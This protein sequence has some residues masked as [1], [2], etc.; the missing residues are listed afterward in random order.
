MLSCLLCMYIDCPVNQ[1][2][3]VLRRSVMYFCYCTHG[4]VCQLVIKENDDDDD[5][6]TE[7]V[8]FSAVFITSSFAILRRNLWNGNKFTLLDER[9][10]SD[11][12][13]PIGT[14]NTSYPGGIKRDFSPSAVQIYL[15]CI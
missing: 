3:P 5:D 2:G 7:A 8:Q 1:Y 10:I 9:R 15:K 4:C 12:Q 14:N 6:A 11:R 13:G